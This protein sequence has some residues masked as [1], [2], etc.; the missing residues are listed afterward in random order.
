[1]AIS[2]TTEFYITAS[3]LNGCTATIPFTVNAA[4]GESPISDNISICELEANVDLTALL[5]P[6]GL[7]GIWSGP[8][9]NGNNFSALGLQGNVLLQ[10]DP[11]NLCFADGDLNVEIISPQLLSLGTDEIC[12]GTDLYNLEVLLDPAFIDGTWSGF[13]VEGYFF[14]PGSLSGTVL[15]TFTP[16]EGCAGPATTTITIQPEPFAEIINEVIVCEGTEILM[17]DYILNAFGNDISFHS[18]IPADPSNAINNTNITV[19]NTVQY[20]VK[21]TNQNGCFFVQPI[22]IITTPGGTPDLGIE[23]VCKN[24]GIYNLNLLNDPAA[25]TGV[26]SG[27]GVI[28]NQLQLNLLSGIVSVTFTPDNL[29]YE[30]ATTYVEIRNP[31][32]LNLDTTNLCSTSGNFELSGIRDPFFPDGNWSGTGVSNGIFNPDS[33]SG[34]VS[35]TFIPSAFCANNGITTIYVTTSQTPVLKQISICEAIDTLP[36][37]TLADPLFKNGIWSGSG[38]I[39]SLFI[40]DGLYGI[41]TITFTSTQNCVFPASTTIEITPYKTP[42]LQPIILCETSEPIDLKTLQDTLFATGSWSGVGVQNNYFDPKGLSDKITAT[43]ISDLECTLPASTTVTVNGS[44]KTSDLKVSCDP[45][46]RFYEVSFA[47]SGGDTSSYMVNGVS[48]GK[49]FISDTITSGISYYFVVSDNNQCEPTIL[50]GNKNCECITA[51]GTMDFTDT[52]LKVCKSGV[53]NATHFADQTL[54][55]NDAFRFILHDQ[56]GLQVGNILAVSQTPQFY[57]PPNGILDKTYYISAIAGDTLSDGM[58]K[59]YDG[60]FSMAAGVPVVFYEPE[61][62]M[63]QVADVCADNCTDVNINFKGIPPFRLEFD[64]KNGQTLVSKDTIISFS[65][66]YNYS[67]CPSSFNLDA[68]N[69]TFK[70]TQFRDAQCSPESLDSLTVFNIGKKRT[71]EIKRQLCKGE[72]VIINGSEYNETKPT[73][74]ETIYSDITGQCDSIIRIDLSYFPV[75]NYTISKSICENQSVIVNGAIYNKNKLTGIETIQN[76]NIYGCDSIITIQ[77]TLV[78]EIVT[79]LN[80][81]L[82]RGESIMVNGQV[83]DENRPS[84][85]ELFLGNGADKCDS[86]VNISLTFNDKKVLNITDTLCADKAI[87]VHGKKYDIGYS[88]GTEVLKNGAQ[89]GCDS[90]IQVKLSFFPIETDTTVKYLKKGES[91]EINGILFNENNNK[92]LT[93]RPELTSNGCRQFEYVTVYFEQ[94]I[95]TAN[96]EILSQS[97]PGVNDGKIIISGISGCS[98]YKLKINGTLLPSATFPYELNDLS[99]GTYRIEITGNTD[100]L[101]TKTV[102]VLP[103]LSTGFAVTPTEFKMQ[104]GVDI[105]LKPEILPT[106]AIVLWEPSAHVS[107]SD[108]LFPMTREITDDITYFLTLSDTAGCTFQYNLQ[109]FLSKKEIEITFPNIFSPNGDGTNDFFEVKSTTS[110]Q[111]NRLTIFDRWGSQ[112]FDDVKKSGQESIIWDGKSHDKTIQPGVYIY[113]AEI[114]DTSGNKKYVYGDLTISF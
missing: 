79:F 17:T 112:L 98:D 111:I 26:W 85:T 82:C 30:A 108:C 109:L 104:F 16:D 80:Q 39:D 36:L 83:Y 102:S 3:D 94:D 100:C 68:G 20:F 4:Q 6:P 47:L 91:I 33:F 95:I 10:F 51:A 88:E 73:G 38:V 59:Q 74:T 25:G 70:I 103:S 65:T 37:S 45:T 53:A 22:D 5:N 11:D 67:F 57:F 46:G 48:T 92:G 14:N 78:N 99:P 55:P 75:T 13:G 34:P 89:N 32:P 12:S 29:C 86:T 69:T 8:G 101:M 28:N 21:A 1:M 106:P 18:S 52:P 71:S 76:G 58:I 77:L 44:P 54:D 96:I 63:D 93:V 24:D 90:I 9:V 56:P 19:A 40:S 105:E 72:I 81:T 66:A 114:M 84:G 60:C 97:C 64:I 113:L 41:N 110:Q 107:C 15:L 87:F 35:L 43:F 62:M 23:V 42:V 61:A 7:P 50:Q 27:N 31:I 2:N 49:K